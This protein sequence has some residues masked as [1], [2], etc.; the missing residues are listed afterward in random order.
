MLSGCMQRVLD[1]TARKPSGW[2]GRLMY[3]RLSGDDEFGRK[4]LQALELQSD[5]VHLEVGTGGGGLLAR[6]LQSVAS[7]SGLDHSPDMVAQAQANN[8]QAVDAGRA[9]IVQGD[10]QSLPWGGDTFTSGV[11]VATFL[12]FEEPLRVLAEIYRV[13]KPGGRFVIVTPSRQAEGFIKRFFAPWA[14]A[15]RLYSPDEMRDM[16]THAGFRPVQVSVDRKRLF[17]GIEK[18]A[19]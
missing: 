11:C 18:P 7:A 13:L 3:G 9:T 14:G 12:F 8:A 17:C 19:R 5:D 15:I 4:A 16:L 1:V 6:A 10:A 2:L